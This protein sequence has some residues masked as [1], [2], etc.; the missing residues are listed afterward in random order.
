MKKLLFYSALAV[1]IAASSVAVVEACGSKFLVG[2]ES[3]PR[4]ARVLAGIQPTRILFY[5]P[6]DDQ[7]AEEDQWNLNLEKL[8]TDVGHTVE[9]TF[10]ADAFR[11]AAQGGGFDVVVAAAQVA[12]QMKAEVESLLP[13]TAF[14]VVSHLKTRSEFSEVKR[15]FGTDNV[16]RTPNTTAAFLSA[17]ERSRRTVR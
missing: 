8:L 15:E 17:V 14:L 16:I 1:A 11:H 6:Q 2:G 9:V 5:W 4:F 10:D 7:T 13:D 3:S 12:R